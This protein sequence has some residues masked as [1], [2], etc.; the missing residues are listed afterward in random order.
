[1]DDIVIVDYDLSW[2][3]QFQAEAARI[4][5]ALGDSVV[6]IEH[7]GSTA[8][9]GLCAKPII[10]LLVG[11]RSLPEAR[12]QAVPAL[13]A[14]GYAYWR[15]NPAPDRL[16][17]VKGLSPDRPRTHH[18]HIIDLSVSQDPRIGEFTFADRL[19]FRDYLRANPDEAARY[20]ALKRDLAAQFLVNR[21]AYTGGKT[22]YI[23]RI[24][25][26]A[27]ETTKSP[28]IEIRG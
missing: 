16:F 10:D 6:V 3:E 20:A 7:F 24:M 14:L 22:E 28:R 12:Q 4:K 2:P 17:F 8:V 21:E 1:M 25:Q 11:V 27:R 26:K 15:D 9:P 5:A 18:V 23:Y 13:D 19:L